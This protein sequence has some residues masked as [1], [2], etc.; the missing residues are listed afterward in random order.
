MAINILYGV[1][2]VYF[3]VNSVNWLFTPNYSNSEQDETENNV[4]IKN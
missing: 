4:L 2:S 1:H 3:Q